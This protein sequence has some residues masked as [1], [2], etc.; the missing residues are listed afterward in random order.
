MVIQL[1]NANEPYLNSFYLHDGCLVIAE[2]NDSFL[3]QIGK[4]IIE[5]LSTIVL[6]VI[7][8]H[9]YGLH[10]SAGKNFCKGGRCFKG[11]LLVRTVRGIGQCS[12]HIGDGQIISFKYAF[13]ILKEIFF[14][15]IFKIRVQAG[16]VVKIFVGSQGAVTYHAY[17]ECNRFLRK[18]CCIKV[19]FDFVILS[20]GIVCFRAILFLRGCIC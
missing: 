2:M 14:S 17:G 16:T 15:V 8:C 12:F 9:I 18:G 6:A 19:F 13:H 10:R 7:I 1:I 20:G 3:I 4:R 5:T 11:E